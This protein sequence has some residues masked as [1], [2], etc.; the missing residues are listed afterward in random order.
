M[1]FPILGS[2]K[3]QFYDDSGSPLASGTLSVLDPA[4]DTNKAYYPTADDADAGTNSASGD[5]TLNARGEP[6]NGLYGVDDETYKL[7]L[8][9][10]TA[11]T[12][13]TADDVRVPTRLPTLYGKTAQTLADAG[14]V[15]LTESTTFI[16]TTGAAAITLADGVE[17][18]RKF[19]VMKTDG[20][21][22]TLTPSNFANATTIIFDDIGDSADLIFAN[23]SWHWIGGTALGSGL[24]IPSV[25]TAAS[26]TNPSVLA[27]GVSSFDPTSLTAI[28]SAGLAGADSIVI[29]D[30]GVNKQ[31]AFQDFGVRQVDD[32]TTTPLSAADLTYANIIYNCNNGSAISAVIP[33]NA[34]IAYPINT[35]LGFCQ[36]G[37]G[38]VT[39]TVTSD[40]LNAPGGTKTRT[41]FS[42]I[43]ARKTAA[44]TWIMSGDAV[45]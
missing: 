37:A 5:I 17:N 41:Q 15:T 40:T 27:S 8:K 25:D 4:D 35:I 12:L 32:A 11:A 18:Q 13:W 28:A 2:P 39:V 24:P 22:A 31:M 16:V 38:Q 43:Y 29:N 20:G 33:A 6:T 9:D 44:T 30:G 45:T 26:A 3:P 1:S 10:A 36:I 23:G 34:S 7:V 42:T 21:A 14:A 19:L